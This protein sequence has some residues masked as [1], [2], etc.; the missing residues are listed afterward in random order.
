MSIKCLRDDP[1]HTTLDECP[2]DSNW[3]SDA[4]STDIENKGE[5]YF[6]SDY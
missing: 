4:L 3:V 2:V 5:G 6:L 1:E